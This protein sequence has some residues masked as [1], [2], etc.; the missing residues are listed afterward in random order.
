MLLSELAVNQ[1][2]NPPK[3]IFQLVRVSM[4]CVLDIC[5]P[6]SLPQQ[7]NVGLEGAVFQFLLATAL[8]SGFSNKETLALLPVLCVE[9]LLQ[10]FPG[11]WETRRWVRTH[12]LLLC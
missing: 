8:S 9:G 3:Q 2:K 11:L 10:L 5:V 12:L 6:P 1:L 7:K 4:G